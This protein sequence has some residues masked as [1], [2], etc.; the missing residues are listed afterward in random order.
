VPLFDSPHTL[1]HSRMLPHLSG[2]VL[3]FLKQSLVQRAPDEFIKWYSGVKQ[4][5][6]GA[7]GEGP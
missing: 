5:E 6:L 4:L 3:G 7:S 2:S 1:T